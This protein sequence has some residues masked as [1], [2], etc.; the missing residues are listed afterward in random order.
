MSS[1]NIQPVHK[2]RA[3]VPVVM[4]L[5][6]LECGAACL[7]MILAYYRKWVPLEQVRIDCGVSRD[8]S[9]AKNI[10]MAAR[11]HGM[12]AGG[13]KME[14]EALREKGTFPCI[15]H[16]NFNHFVVCCGFKGKYAYLNDPARGSVKVTMKEFDEAFTGICLMI[17]PSENFVQ[18]RKKKSTLDFAARRLRGA[19]AAVAFGSPADR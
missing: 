5:E 3:K 15:I 18:K 16:W 14:P 2:G 1:K 11:N 19:G 4:Q 9:N 10:L 6:A 8:G 7:A 12:N 13:Y 17:T